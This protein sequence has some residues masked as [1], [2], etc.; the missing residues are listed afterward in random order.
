[1]KIKLILPV[2]TIL[3]Y[4]LIACEPQV[5]S[6][7][8]DCE[9][10]EFEYTETISLISG[11]DSTEIL[12]EQPYSD[13][14]HQESIET[15]PITFS[16]RTAADSTV[17]LRFTVE[18]GAGSEEARAFHEI[19]YDGKQFRVWY[20]SSSRHEFRGKSSVNTPHPPYFRIKDIEVRTPYQ[21][22]ADIHF[23]LRFPK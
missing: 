10:Y 13:W 9:F 8:A 3:A 6:T 14:E 11:F 5:T 23:N 18:A 15:P 7:C 20:G 2:L 12:I 16:D 1:M 21:K 17:V 22:E 19:G 4:G